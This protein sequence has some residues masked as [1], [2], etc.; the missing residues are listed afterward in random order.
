MNCGI[1][2]TDKSEKKIVIHAWFGVSLSYIVSDCID[3][4]K[5]K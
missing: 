4:F 5:S 3:I 1:I 2:R